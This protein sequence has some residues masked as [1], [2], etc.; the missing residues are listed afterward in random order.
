M[1]EIR[2]SGSVRDGDA[3]IY[4]A[5][6]PSQLGQAP[7]EHCTVGEPGEPVKEAELPALIRRPELLQE[8][9]SE[10][11]RQNRY[12]EKKAG[13]AGNPVRAV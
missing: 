12:R 4:S 5:F 6:A 10:Q 1:R 9:Q 7:G 2:T 8:E 13:P 11:P 3:P